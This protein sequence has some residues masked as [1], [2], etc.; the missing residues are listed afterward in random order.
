M[1]PISTHTTSCQGCAA[2]KAG[3]FCDL[4][5][6]HKA[7]FNA[8]GRHITFPAGDI[9]FVEG[10]TARSI[11][12]VCEGRIKL[13]KTSRGGRTLLVKIATDGDVLGLS[14][15]L[16][17]SVY[18]V[19]AQATERTQIRSLQQKAFLEFMR[20]HAEVGLRA[21]ESLSNDYLSVLSDAGRLALPGSNAG[22][23]AHLLL[24]LAVDSEDGLKTQPDFHMSFRHDELAS[25]LGC[26]R[27]SITRV[28]SDFRRKGIIMVKGTRMTMLRREAL[29]RLL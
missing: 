3:W 6:Q 12:V 2:K 25:M 9:L 11:S 19:T 1:L 7:E 17:N 14:A 5:P 22:R 8:L 10:Q 15:A 29:E 13:T 24:E 18:E 27:E 20:R 26:S 28:M 16:A 4:S 21:A 23:L